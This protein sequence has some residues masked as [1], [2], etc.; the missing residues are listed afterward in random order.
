MAL[1]H[2]GNISGAAAEFGIPVADWIDLSTGISPWSWPV[3]PVPESVWRTLPD[4]GDGLEQVAAAYYGCGGAVVLP[5]PGSQYALQQLPSLV[6]PGTVAVPLRGYAEH[7]AAWQANGH[8][9]VV[10]D[11]VQGLQQLAMAGRVDHAVVI[12]PNNPTGEQGGAGELLGLH[13]LLVAR[14]GWLLVDEAFMDASPEQSLAPYC[15]RPG[16]LVLRSL[17]KFFGL[18]GVRLGFLLAPEQLIAR[19]CDSMMP[20][21]VSH[22]ARWIGQRALADRDWQRVQRQRLDRHSTAW[23][24]ALQ[25][26]FPALEFTCS[27]LFVSATGQARDCATLYR[28]LAQ[29]G[30]L[31]RCFDGIAG[32]GMLRFGLPGDGHWAQVVQVLAAIAGEQQCVNG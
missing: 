12:N 21:H 19:L 24:A 20:W 27:R 8:R 32:Q 11:N 5:V 22:P 1:V 23:L 28:S 31:V 6:A 25:P 16:L 9:I 10:Y 15:P 30:V 18:A 7:R 14:G 3:P 13:Q 26:F 17:G 29:C 4:D 2:G